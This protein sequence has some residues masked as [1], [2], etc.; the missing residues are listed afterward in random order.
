MSSEM[1]LTAFNHL[2]HPSSSSNHTSRRYCLACLCY[3]FGNSCA[4]LS[5]KFRDLFHIPLIDVSKSAIYSPVWSHWCHAL[6]TGCAQSTVSINKRHMAIWVAEVLV[7]CE[8]PHKH[9][10]KFDS[11]CIF[12]INFLSVFQNTAVTHKCWRSKILQFTYGNLP[13]WQMLHDHARVITLHLNSICNF[14]VFLFN[15]YEKQN[16]M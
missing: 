1:F 14:P 2:L 8:V 11:H 13:C 5:N 7:V 15:I 12:L 16:S 4:A 9:W 3:V 6:P 10:L